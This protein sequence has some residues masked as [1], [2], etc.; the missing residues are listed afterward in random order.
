MKEPLISIIIPAYNRASLIGETL[1]SILV[2]TYK[3]WEC[4]VVDDGSVD[5]TENIVAE[6]VKKDNR[7]QFYRRPETMNKGANSC[8]NYGFSLSKG[9]WIKWL[10]SD[11][12]MYID[13]MAIES[14]LINGYSNI[15]LS[16]LVL[17]DFGKKEEIKKSNIFSSN[18]IHDYFIAKVALY[19]S[20]PLWERKFLNK[21]EYLFDEKIS[22]VDDW[23]FNMRMLY[24][25]PI[26]R[27]NEKPTILYRMHDNSLSNEIRKGNK[28]EIISV[29][30]ALEKHLKLIKIN[31]ITP[32]KP[33]LQYTIKY[34][35]TTIYN[36]LLA[37]K[38]YSFYIY[39]RLVKIHFFNFYNFKELAK[40]SLGFLV[41]KVCNKGYVFFK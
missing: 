9:E 3:N 32:Y 13:T 25:K 4:I 17:Y 7:F 18:L 28:I 27:Y 35:K 23:D 36:S 10:D 29:L 8:R 22:N 5:N 40:V 19:V 33:L 30:N 37:N 20:G 2:Q 38:N 39:S 21:Q 11:D 6:Y 26:I 24:K 16:P 1:D 15:V 12:L 31:K 41:Y 34:Y 14:R